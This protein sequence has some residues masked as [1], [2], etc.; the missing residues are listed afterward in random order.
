MEEI[1]TTLG[2]PGIIISGF[3]F[4]FAILNLIGELCEKAG[5]IVPEFMKIRKYFQRKKEQSVTT[6]Q[7]LEHVKTLLTDANTLLAD[8][9]SHYDKDNIAKRDKWITEV[10][11]TIEWVHERAHLYDES[12]EW[13]HE[14]AHLYDE[15]IDLLRTTAENSAIALDNNTKLTEEMFVQQ[16]R[17]RILDFAFKVA[18]PENIV[19]RE[20]FDRIFKVHAKYENFLQE[21]DM[22]N[23]EVDIAFRLIQEEYTDRMR[24]GKFLENRRG[25]N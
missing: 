4:I 23:G 2:I 6:Q 5:K 13:V 3:V 22:E 19:S 25:Y 8:V 20:E 24:H 21:H 11:N 18:N 15:S 1:L 7:T 14:R 9:K 16:S 12:I 10:N 17:D